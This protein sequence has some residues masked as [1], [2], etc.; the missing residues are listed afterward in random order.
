MFPKETDT[1]ENFFRNNRNAQWQTVNL[2]KDRINKLKNMG[3]DKYENNLSDKTKNFIKKI[4]SMP[5]ELVPIYFG[6]KVN[7]KPTGFS[8]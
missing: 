4:D 7:A 5:P 3:L 6:Q 1:L 2:L 8:K